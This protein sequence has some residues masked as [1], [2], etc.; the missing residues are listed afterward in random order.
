MKTLI[1]PFINFL[2]VLADFALFAYI[3][4]DAVRDSNKAGA[5]KAEEKK[6]IIEVKEEP[7]PEDETVVEKLENPSVDDLLFF[8]KVE[9]L[10]VRDM[11]FCEQELSRDEVASAIGTNRTY[12]ARSIKTA[13]GKTFSE[14]ITDLRTSYA[15]KLLT[16]TDEPLDLIGTLSGFRSKSAYYRAFA[17]AYDCSPS[18][19]RNNSVSHSISE[20]DKVE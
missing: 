2:A 17:A 8:Q 9:V 13:T 16:T 20:S 6:E 4:I 18:D 1:A 12:L 11:L 15:A 10:M 7:E 3:L 14:Y 19:Y 5:P